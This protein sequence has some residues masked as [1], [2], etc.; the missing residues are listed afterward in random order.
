MTIY[1]GVDIIE[2]IQKIATNGS[3]PVKPA[4]FLQVFALNKPI[5]IQSCIFKIQV[6]LVDDSGL[7]RT[8]CFAEIENATEYLQ[9]IP[10]S[11]FNIPV[12][13]GF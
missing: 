8:V 1:C 3:D 11:H 5:Q 7:A 2:V 4:F 13:V 12:S 9:L 10:S 6:H